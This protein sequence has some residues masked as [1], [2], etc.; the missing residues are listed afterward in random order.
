MIWLWLAMV[1]HAIA[2]PFFW[3]AY[4]VTALAGRA[5]SRGLASKGVDINAIAERHR[6]ETQ[7]RFLPDCDD[8]D[9]GG[10]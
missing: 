4:A 6:Q 1:L 2:A 5:G 8:D 7:R 3:I 9:T 10:D